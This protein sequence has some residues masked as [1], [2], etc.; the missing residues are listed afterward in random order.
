MGPARLSAIDSGPLVAPSRRTPGRRLRLRRIRLPS[1]ASATD[2]V[3]RGTA[4]EGPSLWHADV[5]E[6][7]GSRTGLVGNRGDARSSNDNKLS[8]W[9]CKGLSAERL[10]ECGIPKCVLAYGAPSHQVDFF[11]RING[12]E[13]FVNVNDHV[14]ECD[15]IILE[16]DKSRQGIILKEVLNPPV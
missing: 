5:G 6:G 1:E 16:R 13:D 7:D 15:G 8:M 11:R 14:L 4:K 10:S 3:R 9:T 2:S 12:H